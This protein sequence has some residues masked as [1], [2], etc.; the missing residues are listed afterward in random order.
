MASR[1]SNALEAKADLAASVIACDQVI[2]E[3]LPAAVSA[4]W[5]LR[6][7]EH[8]RCVIT[9][10]LSDPFEHAVTGDFAPDELTFHD[11]VRR[12]VYELVGDL[13]QA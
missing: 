9:L 5:D 11:C 1:L 2:D 10:R 3:V 4:Y 6:I 13:I 12:R 8:Q 7:D